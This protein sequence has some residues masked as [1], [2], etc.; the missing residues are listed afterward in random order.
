MRPYPAFV[1]AAAVALG[2]TSSSACAPSTR[3]AAPAD[4]VPGAAADAYPDVPASAPIGARI[5]KYLDVPPSAQGPAVDPAKGYRRQDLGRGL[6]MVT[7]NVYQSLFLVHEG[8]VVVVD[9]PPNVA[10]HIPKAIAESSWRRR[11]AC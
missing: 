10:A 6:H 8:G 11:S 4:V 1:N 7:D 3:A 9:A 2:I 5:G